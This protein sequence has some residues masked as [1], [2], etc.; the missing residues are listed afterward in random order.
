MTH[1]IAK[2]LIHIAIRGGT[3]RFVDSNRPPA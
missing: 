2:G 3:W 1:Y